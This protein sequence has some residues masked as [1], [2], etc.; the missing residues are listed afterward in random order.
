MTRRLLV[1][2]SAACLAIVADALAQG[3]NRSTAVLLVNAGEYFGTTYTAP[4]AERSTYMF[5]VGEPVKVRGDRESRRHH[6]DPSH[7]R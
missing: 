6:A 5:L 7:A 2:C 1:F 3:L 4:P